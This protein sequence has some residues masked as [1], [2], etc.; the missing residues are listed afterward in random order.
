VD[1]EE[2]EEVAIAS[3]RG[4]DQDMG[5]ADV[6]SRVALVAPTLPLE[7]SSGAPLVAPVPVAEGVALVALAMAVE[8][9]T[10][11]PMSVA[12]SVFAPV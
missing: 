10:S 6:H 12:H 1:Q 8:S 7:A 4:K 9:E 5:Q 3:V 2:G 11:P